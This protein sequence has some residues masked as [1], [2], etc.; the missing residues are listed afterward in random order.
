MRKERIESLKFMRVVAMNLVVLIHVT[1]PAMVN[2]PPDHFLYDIYLMLNR[3]TRFEGAVFVFLS[4]LVLFYNYED[5]PYTLKTWLTFY[6]RRF[7]FILGPYLVWSIFYELFSYYMGYRQY[8]GLR[9]IWD[10]LLVGG[11]YYQLYFI[12]ILVQLFFFTPFFI[13]LIKKFKFL[14]RY[15]FI[16]G[17]VLEFLYTMWNSETG[18]ITFPFFM[19]YLGSFFFGG[20][21]G[22]HYQKVKH[23]WNKK[24]AFG[25]AAMTIAFGLLYTYAFYYSYTIG[26]PIMSYSMLTIVKLLFFAA[27]CYLLFKMG[28]WIEQSAPSPILAVIERL[29]IYSFGFYL[30]HPFILVI[31]SNLLVAE[32]FLEFNIYIALRFPLVMLSTYLFIR[33]FHIMFPKAWFLFGN[34]PA[35]KK[36]SP[37]PSKS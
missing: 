32:T 13:Y 26:D 11:S 29:R 1:A 18:A 30:V 35:I 6:R 15:F 27:S 20:W 12:M 25:F 9:A 23:L 17:F 24:A 2:V 22:V 5:K 7:M 37:E 14:N 16:I 10:N 4:G 31:W 21:V 33:V 36:E 3:F 19:V 8:E 34:L 28:T